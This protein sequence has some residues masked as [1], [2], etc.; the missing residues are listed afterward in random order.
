MAIYDK[1][2]RLL[3]Q[4][5]VKEFGLKQGDTFFREQAFAWFHENYP[6]V[7]DGTIAAHLI[8]MSTNAPSR[9][10]YLGKPPENDD[11]LY[12][13]DSRTFRLYNSSTDP[14]PIYGIGA[15]ATEEDDGVDEASNATEFAYEKDLQNFLAKNLATIE[16]GL[17]LYVEEGIT[18]VEF[19]AGTRFID[20]LALDRE[21]NYVVIEL[22]FTQQA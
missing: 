6:K 21:N 9:A 2:V 18:G 1:P 8:R 10:Y 14:Q 5:M 19:P 3:M 17:Q 20:I 22:V 15:E 11:L 4:D 7:K 13:I 16:P 12:Q